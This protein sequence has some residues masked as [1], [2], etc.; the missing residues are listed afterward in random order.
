MAK[1]KRIPAGAPIPAKAAAARTSGVPCVEDGFVGIPKTN[2]IVDAVYALDIE[3]DVADLPLVSGAQVGQTIHILVADG[4]LS[5]TNKGT[6]GGAGT[7]PLGRVVA[8][9]NDP[10]TDPAP[11]T[12]RMH[13]LRF[14]QTP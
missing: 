8:V 12:G 3:Q 5:V 14:P 1:T 11:K 10:R 13:V 6:A 9:P 7:V 4:T 2:A